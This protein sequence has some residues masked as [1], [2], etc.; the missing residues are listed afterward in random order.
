M[1]IR[2]PAE[3]QGYIPIGRIV[4]A[5]GL[6]GEVKVEPLTNIES[7]FKK[8]KTLH[9][10]GVG[11]VCFEAIRSQKGRYV[12]KLS[13]ITKVEDAE[14]LQW[15]HLYVPA[16]DVPE[17]EQG[18]YLVDDLIGL[19]VRTTDGRDIGEVENVLQYPAH[20]ILVVGSILI[21]AIPEFVEMVDF[22]AEVITVRLIEGMEDA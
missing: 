10:E 12:A 6:L 22:E 3:V 1:K 14:T 18:E 16:S 4:G 13:G 9:L 20:D 5:F 7:R 19:A 21:P 15:R 11:E 8:G 17:L 2:P